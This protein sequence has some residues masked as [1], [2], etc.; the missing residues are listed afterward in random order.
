MNF[1]RNEILVSGTSLSHFTNPVVEYGDRNL[2]LPTTTYTNNDVLTSRPSGEESV[3]T[4]PRHLDHSELLTPDI[5][6]HPDDHA[7]S[8][9]DND[10]SWRVGLANML[11]KDPLHTSVEIHVYSCNLYTVH[12]YSESKVLISFDATV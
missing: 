6:L 8:K 4:Y 12:S 1:S 3:H 5:S 2:R 10:I 9:P 11:C 7:C